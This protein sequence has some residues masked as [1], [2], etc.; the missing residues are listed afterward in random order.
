MQLLSFIRE[1]EVQTIKTATFYLKMPRYG[2]DA[3]GMHHGYS[4][5]ILHTHKKK[6]KKK[7]N[8]LCDMTQYVAHFEVSSHQ[9]IMDM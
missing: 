5:E 3:V 4:K 9:Y 8:Y 2:M 6:K 7:V 1:V